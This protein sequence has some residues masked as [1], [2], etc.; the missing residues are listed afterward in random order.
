MDGM[1]DKRIEDEGGAIVLH[2]QRWRNGPISTAEI[3]KLEE[4]EKEVT[5]LVGVGYLEEAGM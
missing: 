4:L 1:G 2:W 5:V 3:Y